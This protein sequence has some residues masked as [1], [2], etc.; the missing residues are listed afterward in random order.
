M[1]PKI[2]PYRKNGVAVL[3]RQG[4]FSC[5]KGTK[6]TINHIRSSLLQ[7]Q[8]NEDI[9][10]SSVIKTT[11]NVPFLSLEIGHYTVKARFKIVV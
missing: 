10:Y 3:P 5:V 6:Y 2:W 9:A 1:G 4:Q 8:P 11:V 7:R